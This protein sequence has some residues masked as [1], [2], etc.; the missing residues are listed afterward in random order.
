[1]PQ[2]GLETEIVDRSVYENSLQRFREAG[3]VLPTFGEL[4]EPAGI[5][6]EVQ[7]RLADVDP[8]EPHPL[9]LFRVH[10]HNGPDRNLLTEVPEHLVLPESLTGVAAKIVLLL[11]DR[12]PMIHAH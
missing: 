2:L 1:M 7:A 6:D 11:G 10:W 12:F 4:A 8:D 3:I 9:N 5:P